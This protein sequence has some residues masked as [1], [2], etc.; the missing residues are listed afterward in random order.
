MYGSI[1]QLFL[2][3]H[4]AAADWARKA[5]SVP[6]SHYW[7][8]AALVASLGHLDRPDETRSAVEE[9]LQ[10]KPKFTCSYAKKHLFYIKSLAQVDHYIEGLR[11]A[12]VPE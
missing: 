5:V 11:K 6:N 4:E 1:T 12:G 7:A 10:R 2:E 3:R 8:N 9:L